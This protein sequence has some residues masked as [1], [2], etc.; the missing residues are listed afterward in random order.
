M[1]IYKKTLIKKHYTR[2]IYLQKCAQILYEFGAQTYNI[3][4]LNILDFGPIR[5][6]QTGRQTANMKIVIPVTKFT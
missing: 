2:Y 4:Q 6:K 3:V 5:I 1:Y